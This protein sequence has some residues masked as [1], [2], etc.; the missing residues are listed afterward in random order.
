M[1]TQNWKAPAGLFVAA[2]M[3]ATSV[4]C[5]DASAINIRIDYTY[6]TNDFFGAGNPDGAAAGA[7]ARTTLEAAA[8]YFS[9]LLEDT[10][11]AIEVPPTYSSQVFNG[12]VNWDWNATFTHPGTGNT[13][14]LSAPT[15]MEDEFVVYAGGRSLSGSTLGRGGPG[16]FGWSS[17]PSGGFF[18]TQEIA[19]LNA[20]TDA[21]A[22]AVEDRE[23][24]SG[25]ASWGGSLTFD[26]DTSTDWNFSLV[27]LPLSNQDDFFSV[28][29]HE[30]G[31]TLGLGT[32]SEWSN[33]LSGG[34]FIGPNVVAEFGGPVPADTGHFE[35]DVMSVVLGTTIAQEVAM[36]PNI[37][38]GTRKLWTKIDAAALTDIGWT[39]GNPVPEPTSALL[40]VGVAAIAGCRWSRRAS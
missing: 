27:N 39:V 23:E 17:N 8:N 12:Q 15:I 11:S 9:V 33:F 1:T 5:T 32:S 14:S 6:D 7:Q 2:A 28:A 13:L 31:H 35:E 26:S 10:F 40:I 20:I 30:L 24:T 19:E 25:F 36:D 37:T 16:G 29:L 22:S 4:L 38:E 34:N 18:T 3:L 21:F